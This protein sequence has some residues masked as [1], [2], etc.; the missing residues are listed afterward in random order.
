LR[1]ALCF[2]GQGSQSAGMAGNLIDAPAAA[3]LLDVARGEGL[4]LE[5]A[6][7][8]TDDQLRPTEVAQ[9]ALL[10]V[11]SVLTSA[12]P[13]D[14]P[15]VAT[16][17]HSVGE[18]AACAAAGALTPAEAMRLV[19]A[20]GRAMAAM[21]QGTMCALI[22]L[23]EAGAAD[24]CVA[25]ASES[26]GTVVVAN[27]NAP[28]QVVISGTRAAVEAAARLARERGA[29]RVIQLNVSGAFHSP[30]MEEAAAG[31][32]GVLDAG[33]ISEARIPIVCN[34]DAAPVTTATAL[35]PRLRRQLTSAVRW[36]D[37]VQELLALGVDVLAE[38]GPGNVLTGLA[39][40][41]APDVQAITV[42]SDADAHRL[43]EMVGSAR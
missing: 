3:P 34:V 13:R 30:L 12:L 2:P 41:I 36:T 37:C 11:E 4:D 24:V 32:A 22:G 21:R 15:V 1:V 16:A 5:R 38:V 20:R 14:L 19:I 10:F 31:F 6:L 43:S 9:P 7:R 29:R 28:G 23:D 18:Y 27:I 42:N 8:G 39:R 35:R 40:R 26:G 33:A 25:A 17:G